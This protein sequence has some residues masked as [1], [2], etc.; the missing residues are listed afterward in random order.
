[1]STPDTQWVAFVRG[2][3]RTG[4]LTAMAG[5]FSSRGVSFESL[6]TGDLRS[7]TGLIVAVFTASERVQRLLARTLDRLAVVR[8]VEVHA[9]DDPAVRAAGV[10]H[11]PPGVAFV[12]GA[13]VTW[14][15]DSAS[16]Q[17]VLVEGPLGA[18]ETVLQDAVAAGATTTAS[19]I[20]PIVP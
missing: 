11:L 9:A 12:P 2:E 20:L 18:V 19:V 13:A 8:S 3:D 10:V 14:S 17:P 6:T 7:G 4:T 1:M 16:G 5:V 15:G